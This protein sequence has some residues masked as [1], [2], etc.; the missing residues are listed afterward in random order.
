MTNATV[1]RTTRAV[2]SDPYN[3]QSFFVGP[4]T[5]CFVNPLTY[6]PD[7]NG[8]IAKRVI[9]DKSLPQELKTV[10]VLLEDGRRAI[11]DYLLPETST[12]FFRTVV[13]DKV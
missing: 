2:Y 8:N 4:G 5:R 10:E 1:T 12:T 13:F 6:K 3:T 7:G 11:L 9:F